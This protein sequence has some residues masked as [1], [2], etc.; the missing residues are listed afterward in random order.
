M[1][2]LYINGIRISVIIDDYLPVKKGTN[3][4]AFAR[5]DKGELWVPLLEKA[6]AKVHGSYAA[7]S[8]G[9]PDFAANHLI[10][11]PSEALRHE[12]HS[13]LDEL[14]EMLK[15]ADRRK[16]TIM[17]SSLGAGEEENDEGIISGHAYAV[18]SVHEFIH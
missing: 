7:T 3:E 18:V 2:K 5:S 10:G 14:W 1:I 8:G 9:I 13:D 6:W 11:V 12:E 4:L 15:S 17:A 16:F